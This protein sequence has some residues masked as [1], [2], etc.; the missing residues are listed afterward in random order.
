FDEDWMYA[1]N[2]RTAYYTRLPPGSYSFRVIASNN[3]GVW[4]ET[5]ASIQFTLKP[6]FH[7]TLWFDLLCVLAVVA[8]AGAW[9]RRR[10]G[11]LRRLA[12]ALSEQV[13]TRTRDLEWA[14]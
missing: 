2:R 13:A 9:Y 14:N 5:G 1:G 3:D 4:N 12:G 11:R 10:V 7:Q 6:R 8:A